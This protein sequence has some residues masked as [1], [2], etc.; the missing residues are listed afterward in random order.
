VVKVLR[1]QSFAKSLILVCLILIVS[2]AEI[3]PGRSVAQTEGY[4]DTYFEWNYDGQHWTWNL[5]IPVQLYNTYKAV[6]LSERTQ[7]GP[8]GY[9]FCTTTEDAY[10]QSLAKE[11]NDTSNELGYGA[12]DKASF[13][14]AF[15]QSLPYTSDSVTTGHDEYPRFPIETLVDNGGDCENS[16]ILFA[17]LSLIMGF[18]TV[19]IN[20]PS[21]YAVGISGHN[22][23][24]TYWTYPE[25]SNHTYY[26]C[27]TTGNNFMIGQLP[28][29]FHGKSAS[30]YSIN[31]SKQFIPNFLQ[32]MIQP[33]SD[34][35][36]ALPTNSHQAPIAT[37]T[38]APISQPSSE[39][40]LPPLSVN[41]VYDNPLLYVLG[42]FTIIIAVGS[43]IGSIKRCKGT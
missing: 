15:V 19:Y 1:K 42:L 30:I 26:Y 14:L 10:V 6:P 17:T 18:G 28:Y 38:I 37:P 13:T 2:A 34:P 36:T 3:C 31:A 20:P 4:Y 29:E 5:S 35:R 39:P 8:A 40:F 33:N 11:L 7:G 23:R 27:E 32:P 21:H 16:S 9:G 41:I 43:T 12:F 24:G 25:G 22:L